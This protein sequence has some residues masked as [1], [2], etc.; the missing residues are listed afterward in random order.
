MIGE[1]LA[2]RETASR[3]AAVDDP[4]VQYPQLIVSGIGRLAIIVGEH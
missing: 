3:A 1:P 2:R 4:W